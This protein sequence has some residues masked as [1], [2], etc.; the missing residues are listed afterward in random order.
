MKLLKAV[1]LSTALTIPLIAQASD[2]NWTKNLVCSEKQLKNI[3]SSHNADIEFVLDD[4]SGGVWGYAK[5]S[6]QYDNKILK[7]NVYYVASKDFRP[8]NPIGMIMT[9]VEYSV[10]GDMFRFTNN[11]NFSCNNKLTFDNGNSKWN[12]PEQNSPMEIIILDIIKQAKS[13]K[14][15]T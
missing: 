2:D 7:F 8:D 9:R 6:V 5:D 15:R 10:S 12:V 14:T 4:D 13:N 11:V 3:F 1:L